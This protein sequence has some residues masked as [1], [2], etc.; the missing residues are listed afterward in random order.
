MLSLSG[1][2]IAHLI[3]KKMRGDL[4]VQKLFEKFEVSLDQLDSLNIE[5]VDLSGRFAETD[6]KAMRLDEGLFSD[7]KFWKNNWFVVVH[8]L[9]HYCSRVREDRAYFS[10]PEEVSGFIFSIATELAR[11][12]DLES[13]YNLIYPRIEFHF[14]NQSDAREFFIKSVEKAKKVLM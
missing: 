12:T 5:I 10:D 6:L 14:H 13:I 11:G 9:V 7:G 1:E 4:A 8:E 3:K 2:Q